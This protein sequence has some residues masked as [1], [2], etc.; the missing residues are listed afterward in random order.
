[1]HAKKLVLHAMAVLPHLCSKGIPVQNSIRFLLSQ[2]LPARHSAPQLNL[3][4]KLTGALLGKGCPRGL[5][6]RRY[7]CDRAKALLLE[8]S[9]LGDSQYLVRTKRLLNRTR[10]P[11]AK[12]KEQT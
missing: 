6:S 12:Q 11:L 5:T 4:G 7:N 3:Y 10:P 2:E 9:M 8:D 1:M